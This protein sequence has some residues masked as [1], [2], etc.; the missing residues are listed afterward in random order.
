MLVR[1]K[2]GTADEIFSYSVFEV[3][4]ILV[5]HSVFESGIEFQIPPVC[6]QPLAVLL[7]SGLKSFYGTQLLIANT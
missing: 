3:S 4:W 7:T 6:D 5:L 1:V 2:A